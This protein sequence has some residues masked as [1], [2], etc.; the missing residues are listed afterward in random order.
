VAGAVGGAQHDG[1][2]RDRAVRDGVDHLG[3]VLDDA[4]LLVLLADH[5][6]GRVLQE[7]QRGVAE[8]ASW[9]NCAAFSDSSLNSTPAA[10]ASTPTG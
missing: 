9:M 3:A 7:H 1:E 8:L 4:V 5:V 2:V 10:L 6:A